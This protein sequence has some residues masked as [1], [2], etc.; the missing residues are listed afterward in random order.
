M[1][2]HC[3]IDFTTVT[4]SALSLDATRIEAVLENDNDSLQ[5]Q[6]VTGSDTYNVQCEQDVAVRMWKEAL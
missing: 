2:K 6:I 4:G 5:C 3:I 1:S